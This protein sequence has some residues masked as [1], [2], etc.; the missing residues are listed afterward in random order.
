[1]LSSITA[2]ADVAAGKMLVEQNCTK[3]HTDSV[4]SRNDRRIRTLAGLKSQVT[5]CPKPAGTEWSQQ[6]IA[7][8]VEYLNK[9]FYH[10]K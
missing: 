7:N 4:Y 3:C 5:H 8:V 2:Q 10:F 9:E 6:D 1:M